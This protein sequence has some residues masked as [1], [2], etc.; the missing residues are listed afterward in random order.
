MGTFIPLDSLLN[1]LHR[2]QLALQFFR[3]VAGD[4]IGTDADGLAHVLERIL[5]QEVILAFAEQQANRRIVLLFFQDTIHGR[6]VEVKSPG[7][8]RFELAGL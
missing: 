2:R 3:Q 8:F 1:I 7:V 6:K 4:L 5:R